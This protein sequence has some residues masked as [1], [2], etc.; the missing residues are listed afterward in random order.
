MSEHSLLAVAETPGFSCGNTPMIRVYFRV[1]DRWKLIWLKLEGYNSAGSLKDRTAAALIGDLE[2]R[3][4][5]SPSSTIVESTSGN[6]GVALAYL[7]RAKGYGFVAVIDPKATSEICSRMKEFGAELDLVKEPDENGGY[8]LS[9]LRRIEDLCNRFPDYV[10]TNQYGNPA[11]PLAHYLSTAPEIYSQA[12]RNVEAVFVAVSTGGTLAGVGRYFRETSPRTKV[13]GVDASGSVVFGTPPGQ[14]KL[15]GIG[16]SRKSEFLTP[17]L[18][19]CHLLV[20]DQQA[21]SMCRRMAELDIHVGGSSGATL[22]A[23]VRYLA[24]HPEIDSAVC[25]CPD[26]GQSYL[27]TIFDDAWVI[28]NGFEVTHEVEF[29]QEVRTAT[30]G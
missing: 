3:G 11:N 5:L 17:D 6:L 15:T 18:Y 26:S 28:R 2:T 9:R 14:R 30:Q 22:V 24:E 1:R 29:L 8:L 23:C 19:D 12:S 4:L 10:W 16:S 20:T 25:V 27:S 21:F 7:C 13:I